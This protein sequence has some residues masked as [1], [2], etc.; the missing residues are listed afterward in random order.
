MKHDFKRRRAR[1]VRKELVLRLSDI[2]AM[3]RK[4]AVAGIAVLLSV[5]FGG[6]SNDKGQDPMPNSFINPG[7]M[8]RRGRQSLQLPILSSLGSGY[9]E[10]NEEF[11]TARNVEAADLRVD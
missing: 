3:L 9:D 4:P 6:C 7:E 10:P 1:P 11:S 8:M 2:K 5:G